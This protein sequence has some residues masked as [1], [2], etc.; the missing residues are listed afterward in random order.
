MPA[1]VML[2]TVIAIAIIGSLYFYIAD[3]KEQ[4]NQQE[5]L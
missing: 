1:T 5:S 2:L 3:R 4:K